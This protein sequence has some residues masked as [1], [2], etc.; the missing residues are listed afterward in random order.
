MKVHR[1]ALGLALALGTVACEDD[2]GVTLAPT[3]PIAFVRYV[4]IVADTTAMDW[5]P[6]DALENS[7]PAFGLSFRANTPYQAMG[8]GARKLRV[9][10]T[11]EN[12]NIT[13][14]VVIESDITF[15]PNTYYTLVHI[16]LARPGGAPADKIWVIEDAI[17]ASIPAGQIAVRVINAGTGLG[18][19]DIATASSTTGTPSSLFTNLAYEG[20][21]AYQ[22]V[23]VGARALRAYAAG[24]TTPELANVLM[25]AGAA[26][27]PVAGTTAIGGSGQAGS[28]VTAIVV[29]R[30]VAGSAAASFTTP[31]ILYLIDKHP[32]RS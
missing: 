8:A 14:Q 10:P 19:V 1:L 20:V 11:S 12:I 27:D 25:L 13:S 31:G 26:A 16:G 4:H 23:P 21:S 5:R 7:P 29:P 22:M 24:T 9:F 2:P 30:S 17:P 15:T 3:P 28:A 6:V 18:A 32:P